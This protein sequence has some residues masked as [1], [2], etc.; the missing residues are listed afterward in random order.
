MNISA[1]KEYLDKESNNPK[2]NYPISSTAL[3]FVLDGLLDALGEPEEYKCPKCGRKKWD[4]WCGGCGI[5]ISSGKSSL[6]SFI[7][8]EKPKRELSAE[9]MKNRLL[10]NIEE[11]LTK[12]RKWCDFLDGTYDPKKGET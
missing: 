8:P 12:W 4:N 2:Y 11:G 6:Y 7:E 1:G 10:K 5:V 3:F 9:E